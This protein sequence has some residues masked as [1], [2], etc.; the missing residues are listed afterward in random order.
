[1]AREAEE[2][3][4]QNAGLGREVEEL[5]QD[6]EYTTKVLKQVRQSEDQLIEEFNN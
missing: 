4:R 5:K 2:L 3:R 6:L 1:M